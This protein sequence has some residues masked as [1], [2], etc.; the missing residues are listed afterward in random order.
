M[1]KDSFELYIDYCITQLKTYHQYE[2]FSVYGSI[3]AC[4]MTNKLLLSNSKFYYGELF[5]IVDIKFLN[6]NDPILK[7]KYDSGYTIKPYVRSLSMPMNELYGT[8]GSGNSG[9]VFLKDIGKTN[10]MIGREY[11]KSMEDKEII[12]K[13]SDSVFFV[14]NK[15]KNK[16]IQ[17]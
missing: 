13:D 12:Y 4:S 17:V 5:D 7:E 3:F 8:C 10:T 2:N 11:L 14:P 16:I 9:V 1:D 15:T 6:M